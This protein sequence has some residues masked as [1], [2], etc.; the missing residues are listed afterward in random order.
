MISKLNNFE[1][2]FKTISY[3]VVLCGFLSV[4]VSGGFGIIVTFLFISVI[5]GAW[6]LEGSYWQI[7]ERLGTVLI[8]LVIP[9]FYI[10]WKYKIVGYG[11]N[12]KE[13]A[14]MLARM[15][16][17]LAAVKLLQK[18]SDRDW[19][20]L[21][22]ISFFEVLLAAG[23]S[24]SPLYL[25]FFILYLLVSICAV[26]SFEIRKTSQVIN[27]TNKTNKKLSFKEKRIV[28][29]PLTATWL[30]ILII[31]VATPLFFVLPRVGGAGLGNNSNGL[32]GMT[33]FSDSVRLGAIGRLKQN[34]ETVMRVRL[35]KK[36]KA[37]SVLSLNGL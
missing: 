9:L 22:L 13:I 6:F 8:I 27:E 28:R 32:T 3:L 14:G 18:K 19:I 25:A 2:F 30:L 15:I 20:F 36:V 24:I 5:T 12:E 16:L 35:D 17:L 7:P 34:D 31:V 37:R 1:T 10:G 4:W 11:T 29:L 26:V 33:G 23:L 21:Y